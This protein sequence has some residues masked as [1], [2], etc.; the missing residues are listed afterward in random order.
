MN[1]FPTKHDE[2]LQ[3]A[4]DGELRPEERVEFE[5]WLAGDAQARARFESMQRLTGIVDEVGYAAAPAAL[6]A[7]ILRQI[8][9]QATGNVRSE[10]TGR[11]RG[12]VMSSRTMNGLTAATADVL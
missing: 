11:G 6:S 5:R 10:M 12:K 1:P 3:A 2:L 4:L 9:A 7:A 8:S